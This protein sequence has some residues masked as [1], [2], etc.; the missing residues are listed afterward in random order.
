M[1]VTF[2]FTAYKGSFQSAA[3]SLLSSAAT[4]VEVAGGTHLLVAAVEHDLLCYADRPAFDCVACRAGCQTCCIL[5]VSV[6]FP[7][8]V[9]I[10]RFLTKRLTDSELSSV[11]KR[12]REVNV[13]TRW[14]T[15][16]ERIEIH[17]PCAFLDEHGRCLVHPARPLLCRSVTSVEPDLCVEVMTAPPF[18]EAVTIPMNLF[19]K[20][21]MDSAYVGFSSALEQLDL[22]SRAWRLATAMDRLFSVPGATGEFLAGKTIS[23]N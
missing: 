3:V 17:E 19:Q 22:D 7:E 4:P 10:H 18:S 5:N 11:R 9:A 8:A 13:R 21:L 12:V 2:D 1:S 23:W 20:N 15:D 16:D 14:L 6:L